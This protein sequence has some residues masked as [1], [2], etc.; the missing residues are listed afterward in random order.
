MPS[1]AAAILTPPHNKG[2]GPP[3]F[4]ALRHRNYRL[5]FFGQGVSLI[6]TWMQTMAQQV[7]VFRLTGSAAALG[8][9][10]FIG[11]IPLIPL[12]LWG[13]S[14]SDRFSK[15]TIIL[16]A[17]VVML[18]QAL[19]LSALTWSGNIQIW[20]VYLMAFF[21]GCANAVDL[22]ARQ[23]FT[24]E[25]VEGKDDLTNAIGLN[26]AIFNA[27]R[28]LGPALAGL[29]V[30]ATGEGM[31]FLLNAF[32]FVAVII[33]LLMMKNL[34][35]PAIPKRNIKTT[36]H[37][38][39]GFRYVMGQKTI[40]VLTSL[41]AVSAFLSMPYNTLMPVFAE[42]ILKE[43]AR[44]VISFICEGEKPFI[45]CQAPEALPLGILLTMVGLGALV[46]A[47]VVASLPVDSRRGR[48]L[49]LGNL[50]FPLLL[51][52]VAC[53]RSFAITAVSLFLVGFSFVMQNALANTLLQIATPDAVRGRVMSL[54]TMVFQG[55]MRL[56]GLQ[57]GYTADW[58]G[59][60]IAIGLGAGISL[61]Y[62]IFIAIR[63]PKI[64]EL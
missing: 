40:L 8:I 32:S 25:M 51:V 61:I 22:P 36:Q 18:V 49:T 29:I 2:N 3:I 48:L 17:Q 12:S 39:E 21:L 6:G 52:I 58:F 27:A 59:A 34:P 13:G 38:L 5:W 31:A 11:L 15:R 33:S 64:R 14:I 28:A 53:S 26:S 7:L 47:I 43:D 46:G 4:R 45:H 24:V 56:G 44:P 35:V 1:D 41:V 23:S 62:G 54:Y 19:L 30:A 20:H 63:Y 10:S 42:K 55:M 57:A 50:G 9:V 16:W 37:L 60:P